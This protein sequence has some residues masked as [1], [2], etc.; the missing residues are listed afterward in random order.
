MTFKIDAFWLQT[1]FSQCTID[2]FVRSFNNAHINGG[3]QSHGLLGARYISIA[4]THYYRV[5]V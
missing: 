4:G 5:I 1:T 2:S 3:A